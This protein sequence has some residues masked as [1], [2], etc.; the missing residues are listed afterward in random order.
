MGDE[1]LGLPD[2]SEDELDEALALATGGGCSLR[3]GL[4]MLKLSL[5]SIAA[6]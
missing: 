4:N 6:E 1:I 2:S 5:E 3:S